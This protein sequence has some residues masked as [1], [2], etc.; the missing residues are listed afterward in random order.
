MGNI[1]VPHGHQSN[2]NE[3]EQTSDYYRIPGS[4]KLQWTRSGAEALYEIQHIFMSKRCSV[5]AKTHLFNA[6]QED[7]QIEEANETE[8]RGLSSLH[9]NGRTTIGI[10]EYK[11]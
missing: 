11:H 3:S 7:Q 9:N 1:W 10:L 5:L 4:G 8:W 6:A 2:I